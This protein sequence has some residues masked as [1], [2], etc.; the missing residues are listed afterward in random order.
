MLGTRGGQYHNNNGG[1]WLGDASFGWDLSKTG[2][3]STKNT[4]TPL[5]DNPRCL[6]D[7]TRKSIRLACS[8][9]LLSLKQGWVYTTKATHLSTYYSTTGTVSSLHHLLNLVVRR[10]VSV[11]LSFVHGPKPITVRTYVVYSTNR[12]GSSRRHTGMTSRSC[13]ALGQK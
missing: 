3:R 7:S 11:R 12:K 8:F 13:H 6:L 4:N 5:D 1:H 9:T 2:A 10:R